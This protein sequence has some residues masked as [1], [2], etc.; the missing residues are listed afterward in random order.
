MVDMFL[1][2]VILDLRH[3]GYLEKTSNTLQRISTTGTGALAPACTQQVESS[4]FCSYSPS[5]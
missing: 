5:F 3:V 2:A 1:H 4:H